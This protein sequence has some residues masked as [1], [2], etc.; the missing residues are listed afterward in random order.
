M[1][2]AQ[3]GIFGWSTPSKRLLRVLAIL[4]TKTA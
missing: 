1:I 2:K 3:G 4:V